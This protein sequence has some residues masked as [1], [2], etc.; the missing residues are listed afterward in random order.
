MGYLARQLIKAREAYRGCKYNREKSEPMDLVQIMEAMG[1]YR[2]G[3]RHP[4]CCPWLNGDL[5]R[6]IQVH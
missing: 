6:K 1:K 4:L 3:L 5:T 2:A